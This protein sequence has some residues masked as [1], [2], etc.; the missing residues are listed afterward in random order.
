MAYSVQNNGDTVVLNLNY[1]N[2]SSSDS[3][4]NATL[5]LNVPAGM[6]FSPST[7]YPS[8]TTWAGNIWQLGNVP[9]STTMS[10]S[11]T[12][13]VTNILLAPFNVSWVV[14]AT[15]AD[16]NPANNTS[17]ITINNNLCAD[18]CSPAPQVQVQPNP[19]FECACFCVA[20]NDVICPI[21]QTTIYEI[22]AG[23]SMNIESITMDQY[24]GC[25]KIRYTDPTQQA[26]FTYVL[27][28]QNCL[29]GAITGPF[30]PALV[31]I[32]SLFPI[33]GLCNAIVSNLLD[34]SC[35]A[36]NGAGLATDYVYIEN[37]NGELVQEDPCIIV[38]NVLEDAACV[39]PINDV[40]QVQN[41]YV[42]GLD[43]IVHV[44]DRNALGLITPTLIQPTDVSVALLG[45]RCDGS[46]G[47]VLP[48]DIVRHTSLINQLASINYIVG[49]ADNYLMVDPAAAVI[50]ITLNP[51]PVDICSGNTVTIKHLGTG[52]NRTN[53]LRVV[54]FGG[55]L[56]DG[57]TYFEFNNSGASSNNMRGYNLSTYKFS[58]DGAAWWVS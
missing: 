23:S 24:T 36:I 3:A 46:L 42:Q 21:G 52:V 56:V 11:V 20:D 12:L 5:T 44:I 7:P 50:T 13:T 37:E 48:G 8:G 55:A 51:P 41:V 33:S 31:T 29:T 1:T 47:Y 14:G 43:N 28:C 9:P 4:I 35:V 30:G 25:G 27:R 17:S 15:N 49:S 54:G 57:D 16:N 58:W 45:T 22:V 18:T 26:T 32:D 53:L 19:D 10:T 34:P 40:N 39:T 6:T 2:N 38:H